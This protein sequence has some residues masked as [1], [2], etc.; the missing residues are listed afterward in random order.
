MS[1]KGIVVAFA[2]VC[3]VLALPALA[4]TDKPSKKPSGQVTKC[5]IVVKPA[6]Y[7]G[8]APAHLKFIGTI[9]VAHPPVT[10]SYHFER[11]DGASAPEKQ[12][13]ISSAGSE[14][15]DTW[16]L[17]EA[18]KKMTVWERLVTTSPNKKMSPKG[19][20]HLKFSK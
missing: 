2:L 12:I 14:V 19:A 7:T 13:T 11:S 4:G 1:K 20:A 17:G 3:L 16:E 9:F 6:T 18:G 10:V 15:D 8:K 5:A